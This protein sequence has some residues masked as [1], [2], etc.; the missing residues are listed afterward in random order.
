MVGGL[1]LPAAH[2]HEADATHAA[3][4]HR[5]IAA[6]HSDS[7]TGHARLD[8]DDGHVVWLTAAWLHGAIYQGPAA[9]GTAV[10]WMVPVPA[11]VSGKATAF[12]DTAPPHGPPRTSRAL[13][14]PPLPA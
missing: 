1:L 9:T 2:V 13:R 7:P 11:V 8:D 3:V 10:P 5:H 6:H 14:A 4:V 12:D